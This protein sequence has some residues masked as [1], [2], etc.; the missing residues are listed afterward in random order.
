[1]NATLRDFQTLA[2]VGPATAGD[3]WQLGYRSIA[4]LAHADPEEMYRRMDA[5]QGPGLD[6][7]V[8]YV[9]RCVVYQAQTPQPDPELTKWWAW[10]DAK[11]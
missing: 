10:K 3:L 6:R 4:E 5:I 2:S 11:R 8:L 9:F 7:C 1:V